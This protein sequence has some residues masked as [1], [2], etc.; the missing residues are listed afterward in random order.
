MSEAGFDETWQED[1]FDYGIIPF[2][3]S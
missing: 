3:R 2:Y 1:E